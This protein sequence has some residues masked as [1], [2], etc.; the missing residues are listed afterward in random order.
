MLIIEVHVLL[1]EC[2]EIEVFVF[3]RQTVG[4]A[5]PQRRTG[6]LAFHKD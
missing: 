6:P 3:S 4:L 1:L 2:K 5:K